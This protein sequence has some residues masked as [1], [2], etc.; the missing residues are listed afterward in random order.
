[1]I[2]INASP[3][4]GARMAC[5]RVMHDKHMQCSRVACGCTQDFRWWPHTAAQAAVACAPPWVDRVVLAVPKTVV[6]VLSS[7][8]SR[9]WSGCLMY[10]M[11]RLEVH[12]LLSG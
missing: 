6:P 11:S 9:R 7:V 4:A 3:F 10:R 8:A 2:R 1:M 5:A 12:E